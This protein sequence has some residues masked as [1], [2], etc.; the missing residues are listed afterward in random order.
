[1]ESADQNPID[2]LIKKSLLQSSDHQLPSNFSWLVMQRILVEKVHR[3]QQRAI[4]EA[5]LVTLV[6][7]ASATL[8]FF[9]Y[10]QYTGEQALAIPSLSLVAIPA[11]LTLFFLFLVD[12]AI[13]SYSRNKDF[14]GMS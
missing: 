9:A 5:C 11:V 2:S 4:W 1:M 14:A 6:T 13:G 3:A 7:L 10:T 12:T 8:L